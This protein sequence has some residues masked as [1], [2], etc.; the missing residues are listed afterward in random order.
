MTSLS[1]S[2]LVAVFV[3]GFAPKATASSA[4]VITSSCGVFLGAIVWRLYVLFRSNKNRNGCAGGVSRNREE[5]F[6]VQSDVTDSAATKLLDDGT[7]MSKAESGHPFRRYFAKPKIQKLAMITALVLELFSIA[8]IILDMVHLKSSKTPKLLVVPCFIPGILVCLSIVWCP[9]VQKYLN[10]P[11]KH[12]RLV[13]SARWK[14]GVLNGFWRLLFVPVFAFAA[15][16]VLA[17]DETTSFNALK[18]LKG[19]RHITG[20]WNYLGPF[21]VNVFSTFGAYLSVWLAYTLKMHIAAFIV[22]L[23]LSTPISVILVVTLCEKEQTNIP[24]LALSCAEKDG[25]LIPAV[26]ALWIV[27][28]IYLLVH[29]YRFKTISLM[30]EEDLFL[31]SYYS[32]PFIEQ[33]LLLNRNIGMDE[34]KPVEQSREARV[35][36]CTTM[37][38]ESLEEQR[39]LLSSI[40]AIA[41]SRRMTPEDKNRRLFESH[42]FFD[43]GANGMHPSR[44]AYQLMSLVEETLHGKM[45]E[46]EKCETPYGIQLHWML[47]GDF[48]F[49]LHLKDPNKYKKKKR[50]SQVMYMSYILDHRKNR[51]N[52]DENNTFILTTDADVDFTPDSVDILID[53]LLR[54]Y[55]IGAVCGRTH[56]IGDSPIVW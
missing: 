11:A 27:Q 45:N 35:F 34:K 10:T 41:K 55:R 4:L 40:Y 12:D 44:Y 17:L 29:V 39:L 25:Y 48:P 30:R 47:G 3:F 18:L 53:R 54:D 49:Y 37:Y 6:N 21:L 5:T 42:I 26:I 9:P 22:P 38:R 52:L 15:T 2:L 20:D 33:S 8:F 16:T 7:D 13:T 56:P 24:F 36:I 32:A 14:A 46:V 50:W 1:E 51:D 43:N 31:H 23:L 28:S 19:I